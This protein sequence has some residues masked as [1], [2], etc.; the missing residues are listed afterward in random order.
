MYKISFELIKFNFH[1]T[2]KDTFVITGVY[3]DD[4]AQEQKLAVLINGQP[5][6][7]EEEELTG[8][9]IRMQYM[10]RHW[11]VSKEYN[12][13]VPLKETAAESSE[14]R[15]CS[16]L[17]GQDIEEI[18]KDEKVLAE[19]TVKLIPAKQLTTLRDRVRIAIDSVDTDDGTTKIVGWCVA[20]ED[21]DIRILGDGQ[22]IDCNIKRV[23]RADVAAA[24]KDLPEGSKCGFVIEMPYKKYKLLQIEA[25]GQMQSDTI[26][27]SR[28]KIA[29][30]SDDAKPSLIE[31]TIKYYK[32]Y[33]FK[34][35][36][37]KIFNKLFPIKQKMVQNNYKAFRKRYGVTS[38]ELKIQREAHFDYEPTISICIPLFRTNADFL[39]ELLVSFQEQTYSNWELC[40]ADGSITIGDNGTKV[41][42]R[43]VLRDIVA[44][45]S[46]DDKRI[47]YK[48]L[49]EN[50]GIAGNT[51][52]AI[53]MAT[54]DFIAL[55][56]H[57]DLVAPNALYEFVKAINEHPQADV[58]YSDEDKIDKNSKN[59]FEPHFKPDFNLDL[60]C[61][62][63]YICHMLCFRKTLVEEIGGFNSVYDGAQDHDIIFRLCEAAREIYHIPM[64]LYH[65]RVHSQSTAQNIGNKGYA[66]TG[67]C[68]AIEA[69]YERVGIPATVEYETLRGIYRTHYHWNQ[70]PLVSVLIPN[71]DHIDDLS[72]CID[73]ILAKSTYRNLEF[74][75]IENNS[76]E[77]ETF[78][79]YN[80]LDDDYVSRMSG[81]QFADSQYIPKIKV[82]YYEGGFN[83]SRINNFG[84]EHAS[85]DYLFLL[86]NDTEIIE[87]DSI[88][89]MVDVCMRDDVG[90]V[91]AKL[92]YPD[93]SIQHAGV[94]IGFG[95]IAGHAFIGLDKNENGY[96]CRPWELQD[97][98]AVTAACLMTSRDAWDAVGGLDE[99][100]EVAFNDID[101]CMKV[102]Y[103]AK[104]LVVYNPYSVFYHYESKSRGAE[105]NP[106]KI[107]RFHGEIEKFVNKWSEQME[108]GDP[109]YNPNLSLDSA[110]FELK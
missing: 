87:P 32:E 110:Q 27:I 47:K 61:S 97:M 19:H 69:H 38:E 75:V 48:L 54:G 71:K 52:A 72:K 1:I 84:A 23:Y 13:Y 65:W 43:E 24:F 51:N 2:R 90:I 39:K 45:F 36:I 86:N 101:Y 7:F 98:S 81:Q 46:K 60:L 102:L 108:A 5:V 103:N 42:E 89:E 4:D 30:E 50:L 78:E 9:S 80:Q 29:Q 96:F 74:I 70:T 76:T 104:K 21:V 63:N 79:Y 100:F 11:N 67:G 59:Y 15:I 91:G 82:V 16:L 17:E 35:T 95:G 12:L 58:I 92:Y 107:K 94:V 57:D 40:L 73:S 77:N 8:A 88:K 109:Y 53:D 99:S 44:E 20:R 105:D 56:D 22:E 41:G 34:Y 55:C 25:K 3:R 33:G 31:K 28:G 37:K 18:I 10:A 85:G 68:K 64:V 49:D 66:I 106:E 14:V 83:Y 93:D 6:E 26:S 62:I